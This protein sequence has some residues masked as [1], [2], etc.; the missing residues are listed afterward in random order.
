MDKYFIQNAFKT[1]D[2]I[3]EE[4][5]NDKKS[6]KESLSEDA[7]TVEEPMDLDEFEDKYLGKMAVVGGNGNFK[8][9]A[10]QITKLIDF[11]G[12]FEKSVW[13]GV[14][15]DGLKLTLS[16]DELEVKLEEKTE[17]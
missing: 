9:N 4:M 8:G 17:K 11:N 14:T 16:G 3:E 1:L 15:E 10:V 13:E 5:A 2:E 7:T 6:L 12:D